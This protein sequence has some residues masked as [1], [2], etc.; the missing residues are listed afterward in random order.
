MCSFFSFSNRIS[1]KNRTEKAVLTSSDTRIG[2]TKLLVDVVDGRISRYR[3]ENLET[4]SSP[5]PSHK[6]G[7]TK[8]WQLLS[9]GDGLL[10]VRSWKGF[11]LCDV[12]VCKN[13]KVPPPPH[14]A[15]RTLW[16][17]A[18][19]RHTHRRTIRLSTGWKQ[20]AITVFMILWWWL[21]PSFPPMLWPTLW[22][23][24]L[25]L[26]YKNPKRNKTKTRETQHFIR[27]QTHT[28]TNNNWK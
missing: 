11:L 27:T 13:G 23:S 15:R 28:R 24:C 10:Y 3:P 26:H 6:E 21:P 5:E 20:S 16:P 2:I 17:N 25:Q 7:H 19:R 9:S 12:C 22:I 4:N 14:H 1:V 8:S 18:T